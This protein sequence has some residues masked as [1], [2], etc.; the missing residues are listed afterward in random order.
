MHILKQAFAIRIP[1]TVLFVLVTVFTAI[2]T[3]LVLTS[4]VA[5]AQG[6]Q[7]PPLEMITDTRSALA[8]IIAG[9]AGVLASFLLDRFY[10]FETLDSGLK[11][12][13]A[14]ISA[15]VLVWVSRAA[16][17]YIPPAWFD[18]ADVYFKDALPYILG[19]LAVYAAKALRSGVSKSRAIARVVREQPIS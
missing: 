18:F 4:S 10:W 13:V 12:L 14:G 15:I 5:L 11:I 9:G 7:P 17:Q 1:L 3:A 19:A 6:P 16:L 2:A 8:W